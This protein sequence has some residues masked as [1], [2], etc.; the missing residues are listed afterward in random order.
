MDGGAWWAAVHGLAQ[1][2]TTERLSSGSSSSVFSSRH[3]DATYLVLPV[4]LPPK[5]M[6]FAQRQAPL[7]VAR[8][9]GF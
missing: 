6:F 8:W 5:K 7:Q 3:V 2:D 9:I 4:F 1:S